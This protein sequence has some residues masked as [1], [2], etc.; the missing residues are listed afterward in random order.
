MFLQIQRANRRWL[1]ECSRLRHPSTQ[2]QAL[3]H[4]GQPSKARLPRTMD[5]RP[6]R[7][8]RLSSP[9]RRLYDC[10]SRLSRKNSRCSLNCIVWGCDADFAHVAL[11]LCPKTSRNTRTHA[12]RVSTNGKPMIAN[13]R[14]HSSSTTAHRMP[15]ALCTL[16]MP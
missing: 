12:P 8:D 16:A 1:N 2:L 15:M 6:C 4:G 7:Y 5:W 13:P 10:P 9:G 3:N 14:S 11:D